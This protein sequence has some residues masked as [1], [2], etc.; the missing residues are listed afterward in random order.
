MYSIICILA[1]NITLNV[2]SWSKVLKMIQKYANYYY[3]HLSSNYNLCNIGHDYIL[4]RFFKSSKISFSSVNSICFL[5]LRFLNVPSL[6]AMKIKIIANQMQACFLIQNRHE[7]F[8]WSTG[9][10]IHHSTHIFVTCIAVYIQEIRYIAF[11][12]ICFMVD[13]QSQMLQHTVNSLSNQEPLAR[14]VPSV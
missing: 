12:D 7:S 4:Q 9:R 3:K 8:C 10:E 11:S 5:C 13:H 14:N 1:K 2:Q 6:Y